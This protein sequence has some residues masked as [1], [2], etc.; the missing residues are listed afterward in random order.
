MTWTISLTLWMWRPSS[1]CSSFRIFRQFS[2]IGFKHSVPTRFAYFGMRRCFH[3]V[4]CGVVLV[5]VVTD[6]HFFFFGFVCWL[7]CFNN[8][9]HRDVVRKLTKCQKFIDDKSRNRSSSAHF[10]QPFT[11]PIR[12]FT[13][14]QT[15]K[16]EQWICSLWRLNAVSPLKLPAQFCQQNAN[17]I[18]RGGERERERESD[19]AE[20]KD[21]YDCSKLSK[22]SIHFHWKIW[23]WAD[24][25][26][27]YSDGYSIAIGKVI[28][29]RS[30]INTTDT[31]V[32]AHGHGTI[33][34][35]G[36]QMRS[37]PFNEKYKV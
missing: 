23:I 9:S 31:W 36:V 5:T 33:S 29:S 15:I 24:P 37:T 32:P 11:A 1:I 8:F 26:L 34:G 16:E 21:N 28:C 17:I 13:M 19:T 22:K 2:L 35:S 27:L 20:K 12:Q 7:V 25:N 14:P 10:R 4:S 18:L 3:H 6:A 30:K